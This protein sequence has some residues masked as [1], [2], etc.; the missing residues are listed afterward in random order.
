MNTNAGVVPF[1]T[2]ISLI[3]YF[4]G[5]NC[6]AEPATLSYAYVHVV[7]FHNMEYLTTFKR[8]YINSNV[9]V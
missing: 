3:P 9:D 7:G 6:L 2:S 4:C 5:S 8:T 1:Y